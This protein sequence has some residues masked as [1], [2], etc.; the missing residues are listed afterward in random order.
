MQEQLETCK[1]VQ[2]LTD[3]RQNFI[4]AELNT[5]G[6]VLAGELAVRF[7]VSEDTARRDL[8]EL[9]KQGDCRRVY[10]GA[11]AQFSA[12]IGKRIA[13][14]SAETLRLAGAAVKLIASGQSLFL[15]GGSTN[16]SFAK[17]LPPSIAL[18]VATNS[19]GVASALSEHRSIELIVLGGLHNVDLG[20]CTGTETL[21]AI[22]QLNADYFFLGSCGVHAGRGV[23][24]FDAAEAEVKRAMAR[25]STNIVVIA[26]AEK[27]QVTAPFRV[28]G[29]EVIGHLVVDGATPISL[30]S[31]FEEQGAVVHFA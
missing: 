23:T 25:N 4:R 19:L 17:A 3:D 28:V 24:A 1:D 13:A 12:P 2:M 6:R 30:V 22:S 5:K 27:L 15:D 7:G 8:R 29:P 26:A 11:V 10:G 31:P 18:T 20:T 14:V 21:K 16:I 9:A